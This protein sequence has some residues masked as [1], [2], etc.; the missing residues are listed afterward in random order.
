MLSPE[1]PSVAPARPWLTGW[2]LLV[3]LTAAAL[4]ARAQTYDWAVPG[5]VSRGYLRPRQVVADA[6]G[7]SYVAGSY[8]HS[9]TL[10]AI[11]LTEA[12][13]LMENLFVAKLSPSGAYLWAVSAGGAM[14]EFPTAL[15]LDPAGHVVLTGCFR[16]PSLRFGSATLY[17]ASAAY[18]L[19]LTKLDGATGQSLWA[20]RAG[21]LDDDGLNALA[22][23]PTGDVYGA[24]SFWS[25]TLQIGTATLVNARARRADVLLVKLSGN[26]GSWQWARRAGGVNSEG[27]SSIA[28]GPHHWVLIAGGVT[29]LAAGFGSD[30][31][32]TVITGSGQLLGP[33]GQVFVSC[34]SATTGTWL[35]AHQGGDSQAG[36]GGGR[37]YALAV[38]AVG[39]AYVAGAY[40]SPTARFGSHVI[41]NV[42]GIAQPSGT[43][44]SDV[45]AARLDT[46]GT[47]QWAATTG[48]SDYDG[49]TALTLDATGLTVFSQTDFARRFLTQLD[50]ATGTW[51]GQLALPANPDHFALDA[52]GRRYL[53]GTSDVTQHFGPFTL[54]AT[55]NRLTG[56]VARLSAGP[57]ATAAL[58]PLSPGLR[59]WPNPAPGGRALVSGGVPGQLVQV[60]DA[61]GRCVGQGQMPTT[62]QPLRLPAPLLPG[63]YL[64]R[65]AA[66]GHATRL[67]AE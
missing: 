54:S 60:Y 4:P 24:G 57:L 1:P 14:E 13:T 39:N 38:D 20:K 35:W 11:T 56:Y 64:L 30:T 49:A 40:N 9:I 33:N 58:G 66:T 12:D 5:G 47:W 34:L 31:L 45:F 29:S 55:P 21:G 25:D 15:A 42:G 67:V 26:T 65:V 28:I 27:A 59:V 48:G 18:D 2:L 36:A 32:R 63:L 51:G 50:P 43:P 7:N 44:N 46:A 6:L 23:D 19:F 8:I 10:G 62:G 22:I 37:A 53:V 61:R 16:S 3:L 41:T 52:S 17:N